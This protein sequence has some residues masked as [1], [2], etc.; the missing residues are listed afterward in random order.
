MKILIIAL[1]ILISACGTCDPWT[2]SCETPLGDNI[3]FF[4]YPRYKEVPQN[5]ILNAY[6]EA[7]INFE[8][9]ASE[10]SRWTYPTKL[11]LD[12]QQR[13]DTYK[14]DAS[15]AINRLDWDE[16]KTHTDNINKL[17]EVV[18]NPPCSSVKVIQLSPISPIEIN[19]R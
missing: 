18:S 10:K 5:P 15:K 11:T 12:M 6:N 8:G 19:C 14:I 2:E 9:V 1:T 7:V 17:T 16:V 13:V 4:T 3:P